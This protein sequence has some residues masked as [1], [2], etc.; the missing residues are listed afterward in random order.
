MRE[1]L[2]QSDAVDSIILDALMPGEPSDSLARYARALGIPVVCHD[3]GQPGDDD[4][5]RDRRI[6]ITSEAVRV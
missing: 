3:F 4:N 2:Q 5:C 1:R 6:A